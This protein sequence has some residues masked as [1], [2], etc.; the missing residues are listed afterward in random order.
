MN[1]KAKSPSGPDLAK[2]VALSE[3]AD[4]AKLLGHVHGEPALLV[5]RAGELFA[6]GATCTHYGAPLADGL[7]VDDT[8]RCPWH[9]ACFSLR[10][11]DA[12]R[13]PALDPVACW[14]V[15]LRDGIAY[16]G[17]RLEREG[18][19]SPAP[20]ADKPASIVI[21]RAKD[22]ALSRT[23]SPAFRSTSARS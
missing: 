10:T 22:S 23:S 16:V 20:R 19:R 15:E 6:I 13:A 17:E 3:L 4:G 5:R 7:L 1:G 11:G 8:V 18:P 14:R 12:L 9:H 2:G 21:V